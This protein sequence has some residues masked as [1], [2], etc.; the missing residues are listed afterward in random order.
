MMMIIT[1]IINISSSFLLLLIIINKKVTFLKPKV[2]FY[3]E[4]EKWKSK[5]TEHK[6]HVMKSKQLIE[7]QIKK[8]K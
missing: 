7:K 8:N 5:N 2:I 6:K 4:K 3:D 1:I